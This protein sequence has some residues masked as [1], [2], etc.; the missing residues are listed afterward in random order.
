MSST[1]VFHSDGGGVQAAGDVHIASQT[2]FSGSGPQYSDW[3][4]SQLERATRLDSPP[5]ADELVA[6]LLKDHLA[7]IQPIEIDGRSIAY[8]VAARLH[9]MLKR[10]GKKPTVRDWTPRGGP[11]DLNLLLAGNDMKILLFV[12]AGRNHFIDG[13]DR[14]ARVLAAGPHY[15][16]VATDDTRE[17]WQ[18]G[19][20]QAI[21]WKELDWEKY[22]TG[23]FLTKVLKA[24][25]EACRFCAE[26]LAGAS[27]SETPA[28][29]ARAEILTDGEARE[30]VVRLRETERILDFT[31]VL[32]RQQWPL[33]GPHIVALAKEESGERNDA[34]S[35][36][37]RQDERLQLLA[38]G[39]MLFQGLPADQ[40]FAGVEAIMERVWRRGRPGMDSYDYI[41]IE[42]LSR[43]F[44]RLG[45]ANGEEGRIV[46]RARRELLGAAWELHRR[47]IL[48]ALPAVADMLSRAASFLEI[49]GAGG[50]STAPV[51]APAPS[52]G[53]G[54]P[55]AGDASADKDRR[56]Q[57]VMSEGRARQLY[58]TVRRLA[59]LQSAAVASLNQVGQL[60]DCGFASVEPYLR[61]LAA[62]ESEL[63]RAVVA[64]ALA[65]T[66][67]WDLKPGEKAQLYDLLHDWWRES[68]FAD[69]GK[70]KAGAEKNR[71]RA[72][73]ALTVG[74][75]STYDLPNRMNEKLVTLLRSM[76]ADRWPDVRDA[77]RRVFPWMV[78]KHLEQLDCDG[79]VRGTVAVRED[80]TVVTAAGV[81]AA[82]RLRPEEIARLL[83]SW[84]AL[85]LG[86]PKAAA[87][88][89]VGDQEML[90]ALIARSLGAM[91]TDERDSL[92]PPER[93]ISELIEI[94]GVSRRELLRRHVLVA[95]GEQA[96]QHYEKAAPL[97]V[98]LLASVSLQDRSLLVDI[99]VRGHQDQRKM[100]VPGEESMQVEDESFPIW[101]TCPRPRTNVEQ[102]L[103]RWLQEWDQPV[104]Q[105]VAAETLAIMSLT[106]LEVKERERIAARQAAAV[107][108]PSSAPLV[109]QPPFDTVRPLGILGHVSLFL[110]VRGGELRS[111]LVAPFAELIWLSKRSWTPAV[112]ASRT[113][114]IT[115]ILKRWRGDTGNESLEDMVKH[116][117]N[118]LA[119][120]RLR[121]LLVLAT[122]GVV[123]ALWI[124]LVR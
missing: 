112:L 25:V 46:V 29:G 7:V 56:L 28:G 42:G 110:A 72:A 81:A 101:I 33:S 3:G 53:E 10:D 116:L 91:Q 55:P 18:L 8:Q 15:G 102:A 107:V 123:G 118:A 49:V 57:S 35:W 92:F 77:F 62:D 87:A 105:Q 113:N 99:F 37:R 38:I 43:Y 22:Y 90:L 95:A 1:N 27:S 23:A 71:R 14:I 120:H 13:L 2:V 114:P 85:A 12:G 121:G 60:S 4:P 26:A 117:D 96:L 36:Y 41:D 78:A 61:E 103:Y 104:A 54:A 63:V 39:L 52:A 68:C 93:I 82:Y 83:T 45:D 21:Y 31:K 98:R 86:D 16:I 119:A 58:G 30:I 32:G 106:P 75:A 34:V 108:R 59:G 48:E 65:A 44:T 40:A 24:E 88:A 70:K 17:R 47:R 115:E 66:L 11:V 5:A 9:A 122:M 19:S 94:L 67:E 84:K 6:D 111:A 76:V 50:A 100:L 74:H 69:P 97:I 20:S 64:R 124:V 79:W 51:T 80:L 89:G 73:V 109:Y